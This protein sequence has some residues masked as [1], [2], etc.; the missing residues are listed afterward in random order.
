MICALLVL[1]L[2]AAPITDVELRALGEAMAA[3]LSSARDPI[4]SRFDFDAF[5]ERSIPGV[6]MPAKARTAFQT[7]FTKGMANTW[8]TLANQSK[9]GTQFTYR[10]NVQVDGL[11]AVQL[12]L[13]YFDGGYDFMEFAIARNARGE[14]RVVDILDVGMG[15]VRSAEARLTLLPLIERSGAGVL[16]RV[17]STSAPI[18]EHLASLKQMNEALVLGRP[19]ETVTLWKGLPEAVRDH[20]LPLATYVNALSML[21]DSAAYRQA[22]VHFITL[23]PDDPANQMRAL[24]LPL[25]AKDWAACL[26]AI[27][28][29][30][31]RVGRDAA[32]DL[33]RADVMRADG[34]P[35]EARKLLEA[36]TTLEPRLDKPWLQLIDLGLSERKFADVAGWMTS[37]ETQAGL[38]FDLRS[39]AFAAFATSKEG[40][41]WAKAHAP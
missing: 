31:R 22:L 18:L 4:S 33:I 41:A 21:D 16:K 25:T 40:K 30:E 17:F 27:E 1:A 38:A 10:R 9:D 24:D 6:A 2:A 11:P 7:G 3:D 23:Y 32:F 14:L 35:G 39:E 12:R 37:G 29:V 19:A 15:S 36:A 34:K 8:T 5:L 26:K 13:L 28:A 20:R